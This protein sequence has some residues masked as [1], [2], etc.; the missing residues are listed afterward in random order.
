[1]FDMAGTEPRLVRA[2]NLSA[3]GQDAHGLAVDYV[4]GDLWVVH[5]VSSNVTVH[6][7]ATIREA[8]HGFTTI[9]FVGKTPDLIAFSPDVRRAYVT[10]RGPRPAPTIPHAT[11]GETPGV[12][13]LDVEGRSLVRVVRI[14]NQESGDFHGVFVPAANR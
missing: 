8:G 12:A 9:P 5:R 13:I 1:V 7:L 14:G 10:L 2:H 11:V 4:R 6:P 3:I